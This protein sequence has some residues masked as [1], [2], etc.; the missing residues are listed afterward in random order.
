MRKYV[1]MGVQGCGK[2][3]QAKLLADEFNLVHIS[4]GDLFRD[5]IRNRT[6]TAAKVKRIMDAGQLVPDEIVID[7][8]Q[9]RLDDHDW[10]IG[11][12]LDGFPRNTPQAQCLLESYDIDA[13]ILIDVPDQVVLDRIMARRL[14]GVC[15]SDTNL[16]FNPPQVEGK[17]DKC[18][19][20][21]KARADDNEEAIR[22]RLNDYHS[23]TEPVLEMLGKK[24]RIVKVDGTKTPAEVQQA[25][26]TEL[27]LT[28]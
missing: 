15:G 23:Q 11:F 26:R 4:V 17:C 28:T 5:H 7:M 20:E 19:G 25:I 13:V 14:C 6:K 10:N 27:G 3:T 22:G 24:E 2:G 9:K 8:V 12:I 21:L 16:L 1:I 18:G